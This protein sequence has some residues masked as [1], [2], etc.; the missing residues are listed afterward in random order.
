[1][2]NEQSRKMNDFEERYELYRFFFLHIVQCEVNSLK[3]KMKK[4]HSFIHKYRHVYVFISILVIGGFLIGC[5]GSAYIRSSDIQALS[6]LLTTISEDMDQYSFFIH[7]F[8]LGILLIVV[9]FLFGTSLIG[10]PIISFIVFTKGVQI[11]FSCSLF[12]YS[13]QL[14]GLIGIFLTLIPQVFFDV[15]AL[16]LISASAIQCSMYICYSTT[17][18]ERLDLKKLM[19]SLLNDIFLCFFFVLVGSYL[20]ATLGIE[21]IKLFNL[22]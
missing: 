5:L 14:K 7:Q 9:V 8:F 20:K 11:G 17:N 10:I 6:S 2:Q 1:M 22:M 16:Y 12:L 4:H 21:F 19:N 13:Y 3:Y 18:R 15:L